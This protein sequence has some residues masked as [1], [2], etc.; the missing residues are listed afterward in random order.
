MIFLCLSLQI[1]IR[2]VILNIRSSTLIC[3]VAYGIMLIG[4]ALKSDFDDI[5]GFAIL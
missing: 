5:N 3:I 2:T 1:P 4:M